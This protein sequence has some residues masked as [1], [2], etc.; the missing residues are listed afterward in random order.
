[1]TPHAAATSTRCSTGRASPPSTV[2]HAQR[3]GDTPSHA[4]NA[5]R[6]RH[7]TIIHTGVTRVI[8]AAT[9]GM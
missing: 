9:S 5:S 1:M 8:I 6:R 4:I 3:Q 7:A 2:V